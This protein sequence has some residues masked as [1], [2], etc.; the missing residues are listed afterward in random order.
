M[1]GLGFGRRTKKEGTQY[2]QWWFWNLGAPAS[3]LGSHWIC[4]W[5]KQGKSLSLQLW[6]LLLSLAGYSEILQVHLL[7]DHHNKQSH[8]VF[9]GGESF[10]PFV[11]ITIPMKHSK[12]K[13]N[14]RRYVCFYFHQFILFFKLH[15]QV[16]SYGIWVYFSYHIL[17]IIIISK[18]THA[19]AKGKVS[20][21]YTK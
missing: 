7:P 15:I 13:C 5:L 11:K 17:V 9:A 18:S 4:S 19:I 16:R 20:F 8:N 6:D 3:L 12:G 2:C 21:F 1:A 14:K 10:F